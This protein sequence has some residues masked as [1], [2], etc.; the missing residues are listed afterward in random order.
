MTALYMAS[1]TV[2]LCS[3]T[4]D[5]PVYGLADCTAVF[6]DILSHSVGDEER[7]PKGSVQR[8]M[9]TSNATLKINA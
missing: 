5:S 9:L 3:L 6:P 4:Y 8:S 2:P 1:L 7:S